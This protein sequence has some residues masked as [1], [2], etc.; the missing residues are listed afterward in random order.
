MKWEE[1][2]RALAGGYGLRSTGLLVFAARI[3]SAF[4][5]LLFAVMAFRW[6]TPAG[7]GTWEVIVTIVTFAS[8]PVGVVAF[9]AT[10]DIARGRMVGRTAF[11]VGV[12][13]SGLGLD[14][15]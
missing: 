5:G 10:R 9:W 3:I 2:P 11:T 6:L 7:V 8:Y 15:G 12:L 13:L 14:A 1:V 4:T